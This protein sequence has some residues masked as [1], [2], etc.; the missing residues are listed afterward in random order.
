LFGGAATN[1]RKRVAPGK[2]RGIAG[3]SVQH[4]ASTLGGSSGSPVL[5]FDTHKVVGL[6]FSGVYGT[7]NHAV[8]LWKVQ[9]DPFFAQAG[10]TFG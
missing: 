7:A 4:D 1:V 9:H 6:H 3:P 2:L 5:C 10:I 8:P